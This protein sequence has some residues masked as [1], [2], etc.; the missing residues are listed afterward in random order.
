MSFWVCSL[1]RFFIVSSAL[2]VIMAQETCPTESPLPLREQISVFQEGSDQVILVIPGGGLRGAEPAPWALTRCRA[3]ADVYHQLKTSST[4]KITVVTLS[5]GT[6][7]KPMPLH[8]QTGFQISEAQAA[9]RWLIHEGGVPFAD[10]LEEAASLDT[11]GNAYWFRVV[12]LEPLLARGGRATVI[13]FTSHFHMPRT[14]VIFEHVLGLSASRRDEEGSIVAAISPPFVCGI[15]AENAFLPADLA[16]LGR[17]PAFSL[18]FVSTEDAGMSAEVL[19]ERTARER[20]S[21]E[22]YW[23]QTIPRIQSMGDLHSFL[24]QEHRAYASGRLEAGEE[25]A[26]LEKAALSTY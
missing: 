1:L 5:L 17:Q 10:I 18:A 3:A 8:P 14:K 21:L 23:K 22:T 26:G 7:H 15:G 4:E 13:V 2:P 20:A 9:A 16:V 12:H 25:G 6:P 11:I 24:F 19:T